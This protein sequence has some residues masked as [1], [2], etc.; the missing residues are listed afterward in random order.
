MAT[1]KKFDTSKLT[2]GV[3][4]EINKEPLEKS[5]N[6]LVDAAVEQIHNNKP[7]YKTEPLK[8]VVQENT[9]RTTLD[10][11]ES[12]HK[13]FKYRALDKGLTIKDYFLE[14]GMKDLESQ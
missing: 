10:I 14:L 9:K 11:P 1:P 8:Q 4:K 3:K 5:V 6:N 2:L 13:R 7:E 12:L